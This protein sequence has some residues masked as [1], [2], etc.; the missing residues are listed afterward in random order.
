MK[1]PPLRITAPG[2]LPILSAV[3]EWYCP[4]CHKTDVTT[5]ARPHSRFHICPK[6]GFLTTPMLPLGT[7]AKVERRL[8][9]DYIGREKVTLDADGRPV[10]S[11]VTTREHGQDCAVFAPTAAATLRSD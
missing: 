9:E 10:M 2:R 8:R 6:M 1:T 5:E 3:H 4:S 11:I 7:K